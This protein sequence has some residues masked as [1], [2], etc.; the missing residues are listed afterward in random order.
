MFPYIDHFIIGIPDKPPLLHHMATCQ[1]NL[2][3]GKTT[4]VRYLYCHIC[5]EKIIVVL[6]YPLIYPPNYVNK[7]L[8]LQIFFISFKLKY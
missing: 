4:F 6:I 5:T 2:K 8:V 7:E 3:Y 1:S